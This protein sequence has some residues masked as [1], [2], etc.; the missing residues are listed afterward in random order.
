MLR[1][2]LTHLALR[3]GRIFA[4]IFVGLGVVTFQAGL[5]LVGLFMVSFWGGPYQS[6]SSW[7]HE[8]PPAFPG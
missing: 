7:R 4:W 8:E 2:E 5:L 6:D 1:D 3:I